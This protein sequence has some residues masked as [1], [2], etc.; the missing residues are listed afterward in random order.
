MKNNLFAF[1]T[2]EL[3]Q[4][5]FI[6]WLLN[7]AHKDHLNEDSV[8]TECA[9]EILSKILPDEPNPLITSDIKR[10]HK[11]IDIFIEVNKKHN[12]IIED[13][14]FSNV[15]DDQ[16][17]RYKKIILDEGKS[18]VKS[19]YL[20]I[21]EQPFEEN[22]DINISR[23]DLLDTFSEYVKKTGNIIFKDY[24]EYLRAIDDN[25]N[26]Y[27]NE[28]IK[29]WRQG[30]DHAYKGFFTHLVQDNIIQTDEDDVINGR[31]NWK[32][33]SNKRGGFWCLWWYSIKDEILAASGLKKNGI[34]EM[35][36]QFE[37][38]KIKDTKN[39]DN[40]TEDERIHII[41]VKLVGDKNFNQSIR[42]GI[43]NFCNDFCKNGK[44]AAEFK[45]KKFR[46]GEHMTLGYIEYDEGNYQK[47]IELMQ[48]LMKSIAVGQY[49]FETEM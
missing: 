16:I 44:E 41:A 32:Y 19:V 23:K 22:V 37:D 30:Y 26:S 11:K 4:D 5:A 9:K 21:V 47:R 12:I 27:K 18:N 10:Q 43:F 45:K 8:L 15:H 34:Y 48:N 2:S 39:K 29:V 42:K 25:V 35:Y 14:T 46:K 6:C 38:D 28:P 13:K 1:A 49:K 7:F 20:K 3:S 24:Y 36:L 40:K 17:N 33:V 31:Y